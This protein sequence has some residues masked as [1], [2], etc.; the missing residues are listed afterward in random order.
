[1]IVASRISRPPL[2]HD[3][4]KFDVTHGDLE[5]SLRRFA[6]QMSRMKPE[7][8]AKFMRVR[9]K[10]LDIGLATPAGFFLWSWVIS[11]PNVRRLAALGIEVMV[12]VY[13]PCSGE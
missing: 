12:S 2:K 1:M 9:S 13:P 6:S 3:Y 10:T 5:E 8:S 11:A 4:V 7:A